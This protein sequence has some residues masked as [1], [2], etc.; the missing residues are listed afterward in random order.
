MLRAKNAIGAQQAAGIS[1]GEPA[2][3]FF[4]VSVSGF[5]YSRHWLRAVFIFITGMGYR[6][7]GKVNKFFK[8]HTFFNY[9]KCNHVCV[10]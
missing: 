6:K 2:L 8:T 1:L 4:F 5:T 3:T 10:F 7:K 9:N